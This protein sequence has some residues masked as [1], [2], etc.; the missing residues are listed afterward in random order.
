MRPPAL[1]VVLGSCP[2]DH[3]DRLADALVE[4]SLAACVQIV[5]QVRSVY[6]WQGAVQHDQ[7]SLLLI[8]LPPERLQAAQA[9]W[10]SLH[11]YQVP[12]W[13]V[14]PALD[15]GPDYLAWAREMTGV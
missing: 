12:E 1:V 9:L 15:V 6:R 5:P 13:V 11:P 2:P 10:R 4:A 8:K 3:A 7:E 14:V